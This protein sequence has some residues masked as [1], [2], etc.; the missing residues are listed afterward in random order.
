MIRL[1][2]IGKNKHPSYRV[3]VSEKRK[4]PHA[5]H[6]ELLGVYNPSMNPKVIDVKKERIAYWLSVGA[7]PSVTL[8]NLLLQIGLIEGKKQR[9]VHVSMRRREAL[10]KKK[11]TVQA[12]A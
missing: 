4:D 9:S 6:I 3:I 11:E 8:H 12:V 5:G 7:Q 2:R 1:Q 10:K